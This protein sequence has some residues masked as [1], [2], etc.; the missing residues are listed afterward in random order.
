[1]RPCILTHAPRTL[2]AELSRKRALLAPK[3]EEL[4]LTVLPGHGAYFLVADIR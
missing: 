4:G 2:G 1:M 3:L